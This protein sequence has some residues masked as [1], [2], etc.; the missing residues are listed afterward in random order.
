MQPDVIVVG[1]GSSGCVI[2]R[3]FTERADRSALL[4]EAGPDYH[5]LPQPL[6][7]SDARRNSMTAHDWGY[8]HKPN[9][10]QMVFPLPR[11]RVVGG[12]SAV[13]TCIALRGQPED[14]DEWT[15]FA[16][17]WSWESCLPAFKRLENDLDRDDDFHGRGGPLPIRR[18]PPGEWVAWQAAFVEA[19]RELGYP[20]CDDSNRPGSHGVGPHAM[21]KVE[22]R[23]I[24]AGEA[25][26]THEVRTRENF[27]L[28]PLV[29]VR[30]V[31]VRNG[32]VHGV[33]IEQQ[34]RVEVLSAPRVVLCAGALNTPGILLRSGIGPRDEVARLGC[35][36]TLDI[37]AV[38]QRLLDHPGSAIF[39]R[40]RLFAPT[41]RH[42][43]LIQTVLRYSSG[44]G[45]SS[46]MLLQP[47]SK[48]VF[49]R[50]DLPLVSLMCAVG[51]PY[52]RGEL[53][54]PSA[55]PRA[56]PLIRSHLLE[57]PRD[58]ALAVDAMMLAHRLSQTRP[59]RKLAAPLWPSSRVLRDRA[60]AEGWIPRAC[61]SGYHPCGTA[62]MGHDPG[63]A[64]TDGRG[65]VFG[66]KGLYIGDASLMPTIPSSNIHLATLMIG[67]RIG[68]W[69]RD[70]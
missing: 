30:R 51:K 7:L 5:G 32:A 57:D 62:P 61:D 56:L 46:D 45:H 64:A 67:E 69:L 38:G 19:C 31:L 28:R 12:S 41:S 9:A 52:G 42:D 48:G 55:D 22:G 43:P 39:L 10:T 1:A 49:P 53:H 8:R 27:A 59:M 44:H 4:L 66:V 18:H 37:P 20:A 40:P 35:E 17:E 36:L 13:N 15:E 47:G 11:G 3:R 21:N 68:A 24:S 70:E 58:R 14:Y 23:R 6:D 25:Y 29:L 65:R 26:L 2:A 60:R 33:E 54:W 34:G 50:I 16:P 63:S